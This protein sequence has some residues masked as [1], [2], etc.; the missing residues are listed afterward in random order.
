M[1]TCIVIGHRNSTRDREANTLFVIEYYKFVAP[2]ARLLVVEQDVK[3]SIAEKLSPGVEYI[4]LY[5][6]GL[7]NRSWSFNVAA[8]KCT[9]KV[10][11]C[12]DNDTILRPAAF[13][14]AIEKIRSD[15]HLVYKPYYQF[16]DLTPVITWNFRNSMDFCWNENDL[17]TRCLG[18]NWLAGGCIMADRKEFIRIG[19]FS[20]FFRGWGGEDDE[21]IFRALKLCPSIGRCPEK[22]EYNLYHLYHER[23]ADCTPNHNNYNAHVKMFLA[24]KDMP[25]IEMRKYADACLMNDMGDVDKYKNEV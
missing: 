13:S 23:T 9:D 19:G 10:I 8:K 17:G 22:P 25:A 7:Y 11:V 2:G 3:P 16:K 1:D 20:E 18:N 5:N 4:F 6:K 24:V 21:F 12:S 15:Q 14:E